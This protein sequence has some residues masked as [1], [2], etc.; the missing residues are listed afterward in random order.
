MWWTTIFYVGGRACVSGLQM[1]R[2]WQF[3]DW[4]DTGVKVWHWGM[5]TVA[6][7]AACQLLK[8]KSG[9]RE[10]NGQ[11]LLMPACCLEKWQD[12]I[13]L[14]PKTCKPLAYCINESKMC[15]SCNVGGWGYETF[16]Y[17]GN[18]LKKVLW[19]WCTLSSHT[20]W[21]RDQRRRTGGG[22]LAAPGSRAYPEVGYSDWVLP[23]WW[24]LG[25]WCLPA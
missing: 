25:A 13:V 18:A 21:C 20:Q 22:E 1:E 11:T 17:F 14:L 2:S 6:R 10:A 16:C 5:V 15:N 7:D 4:W 3:Q 8:E 19:P 24:K 12:K 9:R 23:V